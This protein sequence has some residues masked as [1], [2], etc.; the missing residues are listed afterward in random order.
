MPNTP[1]F[2]SYIVSEHECNGYVCFLAKQFG[3]AG[4]DFKEPLNHSIEKRNS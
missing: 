3:L 1:L 4:V 2:P